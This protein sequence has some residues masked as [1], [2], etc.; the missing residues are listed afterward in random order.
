M[1]TLTMIKRLLKLSS[2]FKM[3]MILAITLGVLGFL[4]AIGVSVCAVYELALIMQGGFSGY[5]LFLM[6]FLGI[7]RGV[8]RYGEQYSNHYIA[9]S[10]LAHIRHIVF[11]KMR[12]LSPAAF[13]NEKKGDIIASVTGDVETLEVFFAHTISPVCIAFFVELIVLIWLANINIIFMLVALIAYSLVGIILPLVYYKKMKDNGDEY[14][15]RLA[16]FNVYLYDVLEGMFDIVSTK[17][18]D[19]VHD[20]ISMQTIELQK[21]NHKT[22]NESSVM[23]SNVDVVIYGAALAVILLGFKLGLGIDTIIAYI[24][25]VSTF[26]PV[27]ALAQLPFNLQMT[28][29]SANRLFKMLDEKP[30]VK[31]K[32]DAH[33]FSFDH[34][35]FDHVFFKYG[36]DDVLKDVSF[37]LKKNEVIGIKG[38]SGN[39][40]ST[41]L[42]LM[43]HMYDA[44]G[45]TINDEDIRNLK[46]SSLYKNMALFSQSVYVFH[47]TIRSN[48]KIAKEDAS[49]EEIWEALE[50]ASIAD[51]VRNLKDGLN[52]VLSNENEVTSLGEKQ[53]LGLARIFLSDAHVILLDEPTSNIDAYNEQVIL[54]SLKKEKDH[55]T[56]VIV[57]HKDSTLAICDHIY[58]LENGILA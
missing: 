1:N 24:I 13:M 55:Y 20:A 18:S 31:E 32:E 44:N 26:G 48:L 23:K 29:A 34:M 17:R 47:D 30:L 22:T 57:S 4:C 10:I 7:F 6:I 33:D 37:T 35:T 51:F 39:G 15:S 3:R 16:N 42:K 28:F 46:I 40:K 14:R 52:T 50:K 27:S 11:E 43:L 58:N 19:D 21:R 25:I 49:D 41:I 9:F 5:L 54:E 45:I 36:E 2:P 8:L 56:M 38:A 53:R 12:E